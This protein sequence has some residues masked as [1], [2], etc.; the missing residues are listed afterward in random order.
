MDLWGPRSHHY[1]NNS[2]APRDNVQDKL[3]V[4]LFNSGATS[5]LNEYDICCGQARE[6]QL[7]KTQ[8]QDL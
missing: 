6:K 5:A 3:G 7:T 4:G 2:A 1:G 8:F